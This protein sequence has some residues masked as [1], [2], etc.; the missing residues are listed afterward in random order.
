MKILHL[1]STHSYLYDELKSLGFT[2]TFDFKSSKNEIENHISSYFGIIIRSR[3]PI[4]KSLIDKAKNLK[5]IARVGSGTEN[6]DINYAQ[7]NKISVISSP[8]GNANA[9][10]E[11]ALGMLL[12][13]VNN[14]SNSEQEIS[15]GIW[16]REANRGYELKNKTIG[17]IGYGNTG[18]SFAKKLSG[19]ELNTIFYDLKPGLENNYAKEVT[20]KEIK[21]NSDVIS[22]HA[23]LTKEAFEII[24][25]KFIDECKK[26]FW[27][28]NTARGKCVKSRD[29]IKGINEKKILGAA[30]DVL[31][32]EKK[33]FEKLTQSLDSNSELTYLIN[34]KKILLTP[35]IAG[36]TKESKLG[37]V[38]IILKKIKKLLK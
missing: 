15:K 35:H 34:S 14:M 29:L 27:L 10:G 18:K 17:L 30:L 6:I 16:S 21:E 2:N 19:F 36:W 22:I 20:L 4:D 25:T 37:L 13:L 7:K 5:F 28:L 1:D 23:S 8:E 9:V 12:S 32:F 26:P 33:S 31:E 24:N 11:H 3:I 38:K